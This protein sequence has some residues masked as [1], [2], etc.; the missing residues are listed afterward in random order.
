[1]SH[2]E[3]VRPNLNGHPQ[4]EAPTQPEPEVVPKSPVCQ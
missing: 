4:A 2:D 1:M 3:T